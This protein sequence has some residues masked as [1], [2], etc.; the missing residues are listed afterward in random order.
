MQDLILNNYTESSLLNKVFSEEHL[1]LAA[2]RALLG[3]LNRPR[4][5]DYYQKLGVNLYNL[6]QS[7]LNG[8][9]Y[10]LPTR[11]FDLW[12]ISGQKMRH[13]NVPALNDLVIQHAIYPLLYN[14]IN[15]KLIFDSYGC[16]KG[17]GTSKAANRCQ[18][19][20][21]QSSKDS[22]FL[23]L[24]I[25]KYYY[26]I[27]HTLVKQ[28]LLHLLPDSPFIDFVSLQFP[29]NQVIGMH[30]GTLLAQVMGIVYLN[31]LD[32]Y[33][34]RVLKC[35]RYIRYVDD[36]VILGK[37]KEHCWELKEQIE[38]FLRMNLKLELSKHKVHPI[39]RGVNFVGFKTW[40]EKRIIRKRSI[41]VFNKVLKEGHIP[42]L[43]SCLAHTL[44]TSSYAQMKN[45]IEAKGYIVDGCR[46]FL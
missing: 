33:I 7:L 15:P 42:S 13:I 8:S 25:R 3:K 9:Y 20:L 36:L 21:R 45:K 17:K 16:R 19:F 29:Q 12:C 18:Q 35:Q 39:K 30:V 27:D 38:S 4:F 2:K 43:Q 46:I 44:D 10:P 37:T 1:F 41:H 5:F 22:Y 26:N 34:K 6:R 40:Q 31:P 11:E 28:S 24:D 14:A 32:H 23:Q